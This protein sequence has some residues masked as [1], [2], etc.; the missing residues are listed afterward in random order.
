MGTGP[1]YQWTS[2]PEAESGV[3]RVVAGGG[4]TR[5]EPEPSVLAPGSHGVQKGYFPDSADVS[6]ST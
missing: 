3:G 5:W 4:V 2:Q 6:C 1:G